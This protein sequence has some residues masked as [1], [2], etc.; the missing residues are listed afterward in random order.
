MSEQVQIVK[1]GEYIEICYKHR[2]EYGDEYYLFN[3]E[4]LE[5]I[6]GFEKGEFD[7]TSINV[8]KEK[9][10]KLWKRHRLQMFYLED[11]RGDFYFKDYILVKR[12]IEKGETFYILLDEHNN[13]C[14][15]LGGKDVT[16]GFLILEDIV[17]FDDLDDIKFHLTNKNISFVET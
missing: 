8:S 16:H 1:Y 17:R 11:E 12:A 6:L 15:Y 14:I 4:R 2:H 10:A 5:V 3:G 9:E 7:K 13:P